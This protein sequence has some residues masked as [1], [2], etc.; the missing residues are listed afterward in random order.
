LDWLAINGFCGLLDN[1]I[2]GEDFSEAANFHLLGYKEYPS[3]GYVEA[4]GAGVNPKEH[5]VCFR[6]NF[7]TVDPKMIVLDRRAGREEYGLDVFAE[8]L[9]GMRIKNCDIIFKRSLGH[10][11]VLVLSGEGL[12]DKISGTDP[13][14]ERERV[15]ESAPIIPE[16]HRDYPEAK[17]TAKILNEFTKLSY[18]ILSKHKINEKRTFP[19]NIVLSRNPGKPMLMESFESKYRMK[20]ACI[21]AVGG[22][23]GFAKILGFDCFKIG[24]GLTNTSLEEKVRLA[25]DCLKRYD[26]V[27]LHIKGTDVAS[28]DKKPIEKRLFI[29]RVDREV[30]SKLVELE[31]VLIVITSDHIT[32]SEDGKHKLGYVPLLIYG[33]GKDEVKSFDEESVKKGEIGIIHGS[34]LMEKL[35]AMRAE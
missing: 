23:I 17:R 10:R 19:A 1:E 9:N 34:D 35:I 16:A 21:A 2:K 27:F 31:D 32:S 11:A 5:D 18:K 25:L 12:S 26:F 6:C 7:A 33:A 14:K 30:F 20:A 8:E 24:S 22:T 13:G 28:H 4:I 3:R 29:E 15:S